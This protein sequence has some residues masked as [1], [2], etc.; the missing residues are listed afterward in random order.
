MTTIRIPEKMQ[1]DFEQRVNAYIYAFVG[2]TEEGKKRRTWGEVL[3][4]VGEYVKQGFDAD[5]R[6]INVIAAFIV[7][8]SILEEAAENLYKTAYPQAKE[9]AEKELLES[10][11]VV[12]DTKKDTENNT[13]TDNNGN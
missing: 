13:E 11:E 6:P 5:R 4:L 7:A 2:E 10:Y 1:Q 3:E 8:A 12:D 9:M